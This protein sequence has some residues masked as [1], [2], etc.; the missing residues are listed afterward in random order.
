MFRKVKH[1]FLDLMKD[2]VNSYAVCEICGEEPT[3][4]SCISCD[5]FICS[6]C[7]S[8]YYADADLCIKCRAEITP[9]EEE[10]DCKESAEALAEDCTCG[11]VRPCDLS[12]EEHEFL[13]K[14]APKEQ[15]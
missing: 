7:T 13:R 12:A 11:T 10:K 6:T 9:E 15:V 4:S 8:G 5:R 2:L 14:Y 3:D 1:F